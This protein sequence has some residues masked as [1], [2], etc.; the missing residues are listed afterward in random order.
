MTEEVSLPQNSSPVGSLILA[1]E[2]NGMCWKENFKEVAAVS[3]SAPPIPETG[4]ASMAK[5]HLDDPLMKAGSLTSK[6]GKGGHLREQEEGARM[7]GGDAV[8]SAIELIVCDHV[9]ARD[10]LIDDTPSIKDITGKLEGQLGYSTALVHCPLR[11]KQAG[12]SSTVYLTAGDI[13]HEQSQALLGSPI[14][15]DVVSSEEVSHVFPTHFVSAERLLWRSDHFA[16]HLPNGACQGK[17]FQCTDFPGV[18]LRICKCCS[19]RKCPLA[20][21]ALSWTCMQSSVRLMWD[22][23]T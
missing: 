11:S 15:R 21:P 4:G 6:I 13:S 22:A 9:S 5:C 19:R 16:V 2:N 8:D 3:F 18:L 7:L 14:R 23:I 12:A 10:D 20:F 1:S 17:V